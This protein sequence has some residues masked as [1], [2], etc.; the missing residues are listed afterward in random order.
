MTNPSSVTVYNMGTLCY[1]ME[2]AHELTFF[3]IILVDIALTN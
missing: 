2:M 1:I 3:K